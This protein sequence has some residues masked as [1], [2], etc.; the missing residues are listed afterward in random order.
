M[1]PS[2][3]H[4]WGGGTPLNS[5][6]DFLSFQIAQLLTSLAIL[7]WT[8]PTSEAQETGKKQI[9]PSSYFLHLWQLFPVGPFPA[10][11][12]SI[13]GAMSLSH[14]VAFCTHSGPGLP[15]L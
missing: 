9:I 12:H 6:C 8:S 4:L 5:H 1:I 15:G 2:V 7:I 3:S 13:S 14:P 10:R 11:P